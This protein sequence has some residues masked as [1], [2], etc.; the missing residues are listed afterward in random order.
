MQMMEQELNIW[1]ELRHPNI[2]HFYGACSIAETPFFVCALMKNGNALQYLM[3][4]PDTNRR[5][6]LLDAAL[7]L[8]YLHGKNI[9][10][11]DL[12]AGNIL[13]GEDGRACL[14][15]FGLAEVKTRST[16][17]RQQSTT[18][19]QGKTVVEGTMGWMS[20]EQMEGGGVSRQTDIYAFAMTIYEVCDAT[21]G[22]KPFTKYECRFSRAVPRSTTC[23]PPVFMI[24]S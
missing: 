12:K 2:L 8:E 7:G 19:D 24:L 21:L 14:S 9:I 17:A 10:H 5:K 16:A 13:I 11:K 6:L 18:P 3:K 4:H 20:P 15:D 1:K 22:R 23:P